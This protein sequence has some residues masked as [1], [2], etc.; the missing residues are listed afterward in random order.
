MTYATTET[1]DLLEM[2]NKLRPTAG[3]GADPQEKVEAIRAVR[4]IASE[5]LERMRP[6]VSDKR[7]SMVDR[8][9]AAII[10]RLMERDLTRYVE[11]A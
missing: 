1:R 2:A 10:V 9:S 4:A 8:N 7:A 11:Q 6:V 5:V 3:D